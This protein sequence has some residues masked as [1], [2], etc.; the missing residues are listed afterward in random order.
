MKAKKT[1]IQPSVAKKILKANKDVGKFKKEVPPLIVSTAEL[2]VEEMIQKL[3]ENPNS[4]EIQIDDII[5]LIQTDPQYD[6]LISSIP[7][8][9]ACAVDENKKAKQKTEE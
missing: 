3:N 7:D 1:I 6:F 4:S 8:I 9:Q 5:K 2:F